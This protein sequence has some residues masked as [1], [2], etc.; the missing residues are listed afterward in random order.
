MKL[1]KRHDS[2]K[3]FLRSVIFPLIAC[4][5][6][7]LYGCKAGPTCS[8]KSRSPDGK[9]IATAEVFANGG[10]ASPGPATMLV[11]LKGTAGSQKAMLVL[12]L[13]EGPADTMRVSMAWLSPT[14]LE[15]TYEGQHN[16]DFQAIKYAGVDI[17]VRNSA[18]TSSGS[19]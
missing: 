13:S 11:Y 17:S 14:H 16:I 1:I 7:L 9:M 2:C 6:C 3:I 19:E 5:L 12:G 8:M 10:F 18:Y 15:L 4:A